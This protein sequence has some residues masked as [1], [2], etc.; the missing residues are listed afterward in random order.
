[1]EKTIKSKVG[2]IGAGMAGLACANRLA[3]AGFDL[4]VLEKSRAIGG[5]MSTRRVGDELTFDHGAQYVRGR[6]DGFLAFL[7]AAKASGDGGAWQPR[8]RAEADF[9]SEGVVVGAPRM[10]DLPSP[11]AEGLDIRFET[12][13]STA[14]FENG[15]WQVETSQGRFDF[16]YLLSTIPAPQ[17]Q[18]LFSSVLDGALGN[19]EIAPCWALL[20]AF[21]KPLGAGFDVWRNVNENIGWLARNSTKPGRADSETWVLHAS[22]EWSRT[23]LERSKED[24]APDLVTLFFEALGIEPQTPT[25]CA[26]HRWR[27]AQTK[28]PLGKSHLNLADGSLLI[29]GDW[30]L[31]AR[32]EYAFDSGAAMADDLLA[33]S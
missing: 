18:R 33:R 9:S 27:F 29:G 14:V 23:H 3:K 12:E 2:I 22:P 31:G 32:V 19:V 21:E 1:M 6:G 28:V 17:A 25:Y 7:D 8:A 11:L 5:R 24:V 26:A 30:C 20:V 13:A 4:V 15:V 16:D 10:R